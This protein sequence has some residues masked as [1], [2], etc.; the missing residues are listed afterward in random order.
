MLSL[1]AG[2]RA[3]FKVGNLHASDISREEQAR[4]GAIDRTL[5]HVRGSLHTLS[6]A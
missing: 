1:F 4:G 3:R 2:Y 6:H 5:V